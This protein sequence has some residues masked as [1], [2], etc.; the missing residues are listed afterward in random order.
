M[1]KKKKKQQE[2]NIEGIEQTLTR[3]ERYIEENQKSLSII[4]LAILLIVGG[5]LAFQRFYVKP[6]EQKAQAQMFG[7][8][9]YFE[10]DSFQLAL[11]GDG[12]YLGFLQIIDRY[13]ITDAANL[14]EYY[15]GISYLHLGEYDNAIKHLKQFESNDLIIAPIAMGAIGDAYVQKGNMKEGVEFYMKAAEMRDNDFT[16]PIFL[17]KAGK[18]YE[19]LNQH[20]KALK[21]YERIKKEYAQSNEGRKIDKYITRV[22]L[23]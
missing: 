1:A 8:V 14:A 7:A 21:A 15:T 16:T 11:N 9:Q 4:V 19:N 3:T 5:Y 18:T 13:S 23:R 12:N 20:D 6:Q 2:E 22:K 17:M 10:R